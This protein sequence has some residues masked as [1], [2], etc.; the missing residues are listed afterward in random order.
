MRHEW[1]VSHHTYANTVMIGAF[2]RCGNCGLEQERVTEHE[3]GRVAGYRWYPKIGRCK[4]RVEGVLIYA[5]IGTGP[6]FR[7]VAKSPSNRGSFEVRELEVNSPWQLVR[8]RQRRGDVWF[9]E[10]V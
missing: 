6:Q 4:G 9:L 8:C 5:T 2:R 10:Y 3:W 7:Y 1:E